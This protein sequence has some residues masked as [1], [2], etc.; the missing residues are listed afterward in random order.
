MKKLLGILVL[1]LLWSSSAYSLSCNLQKDVLTK[2][3]DSGY[4]EIDIYN[5]NDNS[6]TIHGIKYFNSS[7]TLVRS[8]NIYKKVYG[9]S[10]IS[11]THSTNTSFLNTVSSVDFDC[12]I[13]YPS[14][15][16][17]TPPKKKKSGAKKLLEKI[18]GN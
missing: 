18:I 3:T 12:K 1:G 17:Y 13:N 2:H 5:S 14:T 11:F 7:G 16:T 10:N 15:Q 6:V 9:K 8:Y 4:L